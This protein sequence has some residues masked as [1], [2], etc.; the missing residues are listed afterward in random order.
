MKRLSFT[1]LI[2]AVAFSVLSM[3]PPLLNNQFGFYPLIKVGDVVDIFTPLILIPLYWLLF[4]LDRDKTPGFTG[5]LIFLLFAALW[6]EGQGMHLAANSIHHLLEGFEGN[7]AYRLTY[8][9]DEVISHYMWHLGVFGLSMLVIIRQLRNPFA[10]DHP[11]WWVVI[12]A[13]VI[14]GFTL[15]V[16]VVEAGTAPLGVTYA[17]VVTLFGCIWGWK[18]FHYQPM[19]LFFVIT[20]LV[21]TLFFIG[22][23]IYWGGLPEFS[24]VGIID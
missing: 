5:I 7:D 21:A 15:F 2:F 3:A 1:S 12:L 9:Y 20:C 14:H 4:R 24:E 18:R 16:I 8:F 22:W 17:I 10:D 19:L 23:G 6:V 13:G 11:I